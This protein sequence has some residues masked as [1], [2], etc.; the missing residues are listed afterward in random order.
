MQQRVDAN[1][2]NA[3][4]IANNETNFIR[5]KQASESKELINYIVNFLHEADFNIT[6]I[7]SNVINK[8]LPDD[9]IRFLTEIMKTLM[10]T[11]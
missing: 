10:K 9:V 5:S 6:N 3:C 4:H 7:S 8:Q 2:L 1:A 11:Q